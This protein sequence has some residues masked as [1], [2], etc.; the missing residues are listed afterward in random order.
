MLELRCGDVMS[1]CPGVVTG[2]TEDEVLAAATSHAAQDHGL[3][4]ID[5]DTRAVLV[6]A[7]HPA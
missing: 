6:G 7:I 3:T 2:Q 1:G 4:E 5:E